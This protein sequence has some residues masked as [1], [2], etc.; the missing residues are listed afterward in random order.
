[1]DVI[2]Q[3][4]HMTYF[5]DVDLVYSRT[6]KTNALLEDRE[7]RRWIT[8]LCAEDSQVSVH[9]FPQVLCLLLPL[10]LYQERKASL[11]RN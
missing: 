6:R 11:T 5:Y 7:K 10:V 1:M 2:S 4:E 3:E 9:S 8:S